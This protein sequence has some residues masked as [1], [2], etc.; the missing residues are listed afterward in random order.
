MK[1]YSNFFN[2]LWS[3]PDLKI[4]FVFPFY[5]SLVGLHLG[6]AMVGADD[7]L[8]LCG[9]GV[10]ASDGLRIV[11]IGNPFKTLCIMEFHA[12]ITISEINVPNS[13]LISCC[14]YRYQPFNFVV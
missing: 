2:R 3:I 7:G 13:E 6:G 10:G 14:I 9:A 8:F 5:C 4:C 1:V 11:K 12:W